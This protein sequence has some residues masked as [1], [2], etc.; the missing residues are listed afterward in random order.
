MERGATE[1]DAFQRTSNFTSLQHRGKTV[2]SQYMKPS[3]LRIRPNSGKDKNGTDFLGGQQVDK[4]TESAESRM[5][6]SSYQIQKE[7]RRSLKPIID[8]VGSPA[9]ARRKVGSPPQATLDGTVSPWNESPTDPVATLKPGISRTHTGF[10]SMRSADGAVNTARGTRPPSRMSQH[11][12]DLN[13]KP[14]EADNS[15]NFGEILLFVWSIALSWPFG[16]L[17]CRRCRICTSRPTKRA[18][19]C[20]KC[21]ATYSSTAIPRKLLPKQ[22][23][24]MRWRT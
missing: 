9:H 18:Y 24:V 10:L 11:S 21:K 20:L 22:S 14:T 16:E 23:T 1:V 12:L 15:L 13:F 2:H 7:V 6:G 5:L 4:R 3:C 19:I 17:T 8:L